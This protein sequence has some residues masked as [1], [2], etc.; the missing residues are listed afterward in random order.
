MLRAKKKK[1][2]GLRVIED[3]LPT[4][5]ST[6]LEQKEKEIRNMNFQAQQKQISNSRCST[7][8]CA[9]DAVF[10]AENID[11]LAQQE[12][13]SACENSSLL[14]RERVADVGLPLSCARGNGNGTALAP[15]NPNTSCFTFRVRETTLHLHANNW[16]QKQVYTR[17]QTCCVEINTT[18]LNTNIPKYN[19]P[20]RRL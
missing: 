11:Q 8:G 12:S 14:L 16:I 18:K 2:G 15:Y 9:G 17:S 4:T 19:G 5:V 7:W 1:R 20:W 10:L 3:S 13:E 6:P